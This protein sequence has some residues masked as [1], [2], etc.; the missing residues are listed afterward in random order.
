MARG[1]QKMVSVKLDTDEAAAR[2][3]GGDEGRSSP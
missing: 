2:A 1:G 3:S